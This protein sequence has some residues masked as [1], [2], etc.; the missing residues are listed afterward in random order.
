MRLAAALLAAL[1][2]VAGWA[3]EGR[4]VAARFGE[5]TTRYDHGVLGDAV[6]WGALTIT[7]QSAA[8]TSEH[9]IRLPEPR[10][11]EDVA[12]RLVDLDRDGSPEVVVVET[13]LNRGARLS[14]WQPGAEAPRVA[15][16]YIGQRHRWLA[17][18]G[19]A[20]LDGDGFVELAYVDRPHLAKVLRVWRYREGAFR[21]V[22]AAEGLTNH[23]IGWDHIPGGIRECG[24]GPEM[25]T[26]DRDWGRV[27]ASRLTG[28]RIETRALGGYSAEA[29]ASAMAC[30]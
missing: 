2:P 24:Q 19:G 16:P 4:V 11:F 5:P 3:A 23:R 27:M 28:G 26:A 29:M 18:L 10:V 1:L 22:A 17:P 25:I 7:L 6:E 15:T 30:R 20:D 13:D 8:G 21:E 14:A 12:P 9:T